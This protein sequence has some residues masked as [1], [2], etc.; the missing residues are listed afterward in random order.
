MRD[1]ISYK[2]FSTPRQMS[3]DSNR[4][5]TD[6][7]EEY[8]TRHKLRLIDSYLDAGLSGFTGANLSDGSA[9][10]VLLH[11]ARLGHFKPGTRLIVESLDRLTRRE[12]SRAIRLFLDILD[13]GLVIVT[14]I[15]GEQVFTK[16]RVDSDLTA[17]IIAIVFL[18]RANNESK[19]KRER[20]LRNQRVARKKARER[21]IPITAE[22]PKWLTL[23][24]KGDNRH[25]IVNQNRVRVIER[26]FRMATSDK[27]Q[28][29]IVR[30][31]NQHKVAT[32]S[33]APKWRP[34]MLAHL[35][36][37]RALLGEFQPH[38]SVIE[39]GRTRRVPDPDGPIERYFPAVISKELY[40]QARLSTRSRSTR[41]AARRVPAYSNLVAR[42]GRCA[43]CG[44]ALHLF[45]STGGWAY[46]R[47][48]DALQRECS[49]RQGY[50]YRKLESVLFA[51]DEL[52]EIVVRLV[53]HQSST[54]A[55]A[56]AVENQPLSESQRVERAERKTFLARFKIARTGA[57][58]SDIQERDLSRRALVSEF[59]R[60]ID[61]VVMHPERT[62]T[63]H[64]KP[65][66]AGV[67]IVY[68]L[69]RDG[70]LGIQLQAPDGMTGFIDRSLLWNFVRPVRN[71][72]NT[73][74]D[75]DDDRL[76]RSRNISHLLKHARIVTSS[77]GDWQAAAS[78]P[79]QMTDVVMRAEKALGSRG[80]AA[81]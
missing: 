35:L 80:M 6:L 24:G 44:A 72:A 65:D 16:A 33:G 1:A 26:I 10:K 37:S 38:L 68:I 32:F 55:P 46:L 49:N 60:L 77:D 48:A 3:G 56:R 78:D 23:V 11:A 45:Q 70:I 50:P 15:D 8:C 64:F 30:F 34:G 74:V 59:R 61:G 62:L 42:L 47:C 5:Q 67:R 71:G 17:L 19:T 28:W 25:F 9:L 43:R 4:R 51:L 2:R 12:I 13:T 63:I 39:N 76:W 31:L 40:D 14:L 52:T 7:T 21:N 66:T 36:A 73:P 79:M 41:N 20:A 22:C 81:P 53:S 27:G 57:E 58:S 54:C 75:P 69:D 29:Q 18:A